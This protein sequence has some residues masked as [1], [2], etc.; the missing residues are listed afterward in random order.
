MRLHN[1]LRRHGSRLVGR[2]IPLVLELPNGL[3]EIKKRGRK[4]EKAYEAPPTP[5][6]VLVEYEEITRDDAAFQMEY[7]GICV[8]R[9]EIWA[10]R[11][12]VTKLM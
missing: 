3:R 2:R 1:H 10:I 4:A 8:A 11:N 6:E 9:N 12:I 5:S 7:R